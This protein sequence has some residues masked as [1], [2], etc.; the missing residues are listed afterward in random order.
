MSCNSQI[1]QKLKLSSSEPACLDNLKLDRTAIRG[2]VSTNECQ[3]L[4]KIITVDEKKVN[5]NTQHFQN[6]AHNI[7]KMLSEIPLKL[8]LPMKTVN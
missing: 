1:K 4:N 6:V 8:T 2:K 5:K 7:F 3:N